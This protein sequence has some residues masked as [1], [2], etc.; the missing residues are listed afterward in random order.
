MSI[1]Q[2]K[3]FFLT[4]ALYKGAAALP[5]FLI[6]LALGFWQLQRLSWKEALIT[7][8]ETR[9]NASVVALPSA[10]HWPSLKPEDYEYRHIVVEGYYLAGDEAAVFRSKVSKKEG[11]DAP[12]Y[13][14][15]SPLKL[16]D[17]ALV[18]INRGFVPDYAR[19]TS[20]HQPLPLGRVRITGLMRAP[21]ER[22]WFTPADP[23]R[24]TPDAIWFTRDPISLAQGLGLSAKLS[25]TMPL[26]PFMVDADV[27]GE[28][29][30]DA[31]AL[32]TAKAA[33]LPAPIGVL[34]A[35][36]VQDWQNTK[37]LA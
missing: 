27:N 20:A 18:M 12:G 1:V 32:Q 29:L 5:I 37:K 8:I 21:E 25:E 23:T 3:P 9:K 11:D 33:T 2:H 13:L 22:N 16:D 31:A 24:P 34:I 26:A 4:S 36:L 10:A 30:L 6:L 28:V 19:S 14:L 15:V 17:G 7:Q 35:M